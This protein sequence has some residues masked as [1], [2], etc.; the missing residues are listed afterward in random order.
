MF[1]SQVWTNSIKAKIPGIWVE[2]ANNNQ[3]SWAYAQKEDSTYIGDR[4]SEGKPPNNKS[5]KGGKSKELL[6]YIKDKGIQSA[7]E[8]GQITLAQV[9]QIDKAI[10]ILATMGERP[11]DRQGVCGLWLQGPPNAGKSHAAR[12]VAQHLFKEDPYTVTNPTGEF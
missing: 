5:N 8:E 6:N 11:P 1:K 3:A 9:P 12:S 7:V 2:K 10:K 4:Y